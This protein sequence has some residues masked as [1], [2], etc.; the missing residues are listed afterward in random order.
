MEIA[1]HDETI[2]PFVESLPGGAVRLHAHSG[3]DIEAF[4]Q[5]QA[6]LHPLVVDGIRDLWFNPEVERKF[7]RRDGYVLVSRAD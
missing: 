3:L 4:L 1:L 2:D 5:S 6:D 7:D